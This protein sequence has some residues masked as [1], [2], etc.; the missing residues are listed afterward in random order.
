MNRRKASMA[1]SNKKLERYDECYIKAFVLGDAEDYTMS[2]REARRQMRHGRKVYLAVH[3]KGEGEW[4]T[5][6]VESIGR[7]E[8]QTQHHQY[9]VS[10]FEK[11]KKVRN[12]YFFVDNEGLEKPTDITAQYRFDNFSQM[13]RLL[14]LLDIG[15]PIS[16]EVEFKDGSSHITN[17]VIEVDLGRKEFRTINFTRYKMSR[18]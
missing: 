7:R 14:Q 15:C 10:G 1:A 18:W 17:N 9:F 12:C 6:E 5:S 13:T 16:A 11:A 4:I 2:P 3:V 8:V